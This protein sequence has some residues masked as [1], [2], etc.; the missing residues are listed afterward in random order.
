MSIAALWTENDQTE[1]NVLRNA[2]NKMDNTSYGCFLA[3]Q[4]RDIERAYQKMSA[5]EKVKFKLKMVEINKA[6]ADIGQSP[7]PSLTPI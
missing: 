5:K 7:P 4:K 1:L 3:Q 6:G 2:P